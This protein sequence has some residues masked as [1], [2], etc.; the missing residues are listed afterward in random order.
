MQHAITFVIAA[1]CIL[2]IAYLTAIAIYR[3]RVLIRLP[4]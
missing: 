4:W 1:L 3:R 2:A